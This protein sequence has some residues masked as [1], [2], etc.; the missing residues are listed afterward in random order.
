MLYIILVTFISIL[1]LLLSLLLSN[2]NV[3]KEKLSIYECGFMM[4]TKV[5]NP[6]SI[7]FFIVAILFLVFDLEIVLLLPWSV[8]IFNF[9]SVYSHYIMIIFLLILILS[10]AYEWFKGGLEWD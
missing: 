1:L 10:L 2:K 8:S 3:D 9:S 7:K 6:F 5:G 4:I